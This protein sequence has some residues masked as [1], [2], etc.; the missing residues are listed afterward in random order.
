LKTTFNQG[1]GYPYSSGG[2]FGIG[3]TLVSDDLKPEKT[4]TVEGGFDLDLKK[5]AASIGM[6]LYKSN[7]IDQTIP[8]QI[9]SATGYNTLQTNV[10][11]VQNRGMETYL[12]VTPIETS[13]GLTASFQFTYTLNR[14]EVISLSDQSD[15]MIIGASGTNARIVAKVGEPFP[16]L[17]VTKYNRAPNGK[18]IVDPITGYPATDGSFH[19]VGTTS[20][21]HI[22]GLS[23]QVKWKGITLAA[24]AEYRNGHYIYNAMATPFDFSGAGIRT[25]WFNR[26]RFVF[27]NSVYQDPETGEYVNNTNVTTSVGGADFW[28][29]GSRN[30]GIGENY[31]HS[32]GF[33]KLREVSIR[34]DVPASF[35]SVTKFIKGASVS[36][37]GRNLFIWV[38]KT[39]LYT[40]PEY[41]AL[42]ADSNAVGVTNI[43]LT[44]P[45][46]Y[47][48]GTIS[49]TF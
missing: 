6:T 2:G 22:F 18:V 31:T 49:L 34:Y 20:P 7:T 28:T 3:N 17:Q 1:Y 16:L 45:A 39:N 12:R 43:N 33:W 11:E 9:S 5:F 46:R 44:P 38:P 26:E 30:T 47:I 35:L 23:T 15:L 41:S 48:G 36:L 24:T 4:N 19:T 32:A 37:Q 29:D 42:G 25:T 21:P 40:D 14:N 10:G 27:P 8:V 13:F